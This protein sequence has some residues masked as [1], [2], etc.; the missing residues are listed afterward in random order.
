MSDTLRFR[1]MLCKSS[2][3][4]YF[5][6]QAYSDDSAEWWIVRNDFVRWLGDWQEVDTREVSHA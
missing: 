6:N 4:V 1:N 3:G 5:V 2:A